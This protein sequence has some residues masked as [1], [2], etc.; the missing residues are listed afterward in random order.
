MKFIVVS[1]L[2]LFPVFVFAQ[3]LP[4]VATKD[5]KVAFDQSQFPSKMKPGVSILNTKCDSCHSLERVFNA[6]ETGYTV[7]G[8]S[9]KRPDLKPF[10][11]KKMRR[12]DMNLSTQ[13]AS[14]LLKTLQYMLDQD[15]HLASE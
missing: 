5:G 10:V 6:L 3:K 15:S 8:L 11:I 13:E 1:I 14:E 9:F 7:S 12:P 4:V 2:L